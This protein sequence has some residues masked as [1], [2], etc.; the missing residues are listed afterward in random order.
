MRSDLRLHRDDTALLVV[1][2]QE[3]LFSVMHETLRSRLE[4]N[5]GRL[6]AGAKILGIP[7][8]LTEQYPKG[9]GPTISS[10]R[11]AFSWAPQPI[12][13]LAFDACADA[14]CARS[15]NEIHRRRLV[16]AGM[17]THICVYQTARAL[18]EMGYGVHVVVDA[19]ASR[20]EENHR[21]GLEL[22]KAAG[23]VL[24]STETV[25]F[26]LVGGAAGEE[27][28]AISKLVR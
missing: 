2:V 26:D 3:K 10:V 19:V 12:A 1:D 22:C 16:L 14:G 27:F 24:T 18:L 20:T 5:L 28:K 23:A 13:K 25:L 4:T 7:A 15:V 6:G 11:E 9:L 8:L 17:E 21:V